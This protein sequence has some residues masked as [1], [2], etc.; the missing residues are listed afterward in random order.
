MA[1]NRG[2]RFLPVVI[3]RVLGLLPDLGGDH[4]GDQPS[5]APEHF[6]QLFAV[7]EVF[8]YVFREDV[9]DPLERLFAVEDALGWIDKDVDALFRAPGVGLLVPEEF[10]Q[11]LEP[12]F[13]RF[14]GP[15]LL[16]R[17]E[18]VLQI[19]Q[20]GPGKGALDLR[21]EFVCQP[22]LFQEALHQDRPLIEHPA[23][24]GH[25]VLD[26]SDLLL[27]HSPGRFLAVA[28][29]E[30]TGGSVFQKVDDGRNGSFGYR[31]FQGNSTYDRSIHGRYSYRGGGQNQP[32]NAGTADSQARGEA[33]AR[34]RRN[35]SGGP[36]T[37]R[38]C[39]TSS[40]AG[41]TNALTKGWPGPSGIREGVSGPGRA[42]ARRLTAC[43]V[44][45]PRGGGS[46]SRSGCRRF[47]R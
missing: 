12:F 33:H 7:L 26:G 39:A 30:G 14:H 16:P 28:D 13:D 31:G 2:D 47:R 45:G 44:P 20:F 38:G 46:R 17:A 35:S 18:L 9:H 36:G 27:V 40:V 8:R 42:C 41:A 15:C 23:V 24:V 4:G 5:L 43:P 21:P 10:G 11:G 25:A 37:C 1:R 3:H 29:N 32:V 19:G 22:P 6:P 34:L